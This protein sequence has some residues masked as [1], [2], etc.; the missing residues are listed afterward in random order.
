MYTKVRVKRRL[1]FVHYGTNYFSK[2]IYLAFE[3]PEFFTS[4]PT[5]TLGLLNGG[6]INSLSGNVVLE[7]LV[8]SLLLDF[9]TTWE[10][11]A[12]G[13]EESRFQLYYLF[14]NGL[15]PF[16]LELDLCTRP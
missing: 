2:D 13:G 8:F 14:E 11:E 12:E 3:A 10:M 9:G 16:H 5:I 6:H 15:L 1:I 7:N 4:L